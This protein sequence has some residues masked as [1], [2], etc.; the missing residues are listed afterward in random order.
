MIHGHAVCGRVIILIEKQQQKNSAKQENSIV[1]IHR[2]MMKQTINFP[3]WTFKRC[4]AFGYANAS[5]CF[6]MHS[7]CVCEKHIEAIVAGNF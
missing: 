1:W 5:E 6:C 3:L 7:T 2:A 4:D